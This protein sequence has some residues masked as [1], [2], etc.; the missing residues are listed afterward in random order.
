MQSKKNVCRQKR[1]PAGESIDRKQKAL[2]SRC[3]TY[4]LYILH[5][6]GGFDPVHEDFRLARPRHANYSLLRQ[7]LLYGR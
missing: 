3:D 4:L 6:E 5:K 1:A 7:A 2:G